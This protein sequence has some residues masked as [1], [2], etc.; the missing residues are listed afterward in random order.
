MRCLRMHKIT[1]AVSMYQNLQRW[2][3]TCAKRPYLRF[4]FED[5]FS[6]FF[7]WKSEKSAIFLVPVYLAYWP[8][9]REKALLSHPR[10]WFP[11]GLKLIDYPSPSYSV[12]GA[13]TS[14][15]L[16]TF[17]LVTLDS[18]Q[19]WQVTWA[20]PPPSLNFLRL[21]VLDLWV[22]TSAKGHR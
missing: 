20:T 1:T 6:C 21:S 11:S 2:L 4:R 5:V 22:M 9:K 13:D 12:V 16:V 15:D 17:D 18:G 19:T 7:H 10:W 8:R 14:R 3:S